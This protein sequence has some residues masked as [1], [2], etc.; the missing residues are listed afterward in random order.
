M[1]RATGLLIC[2]LMLRATCM[3]AQVSASATVTITA[4]LAGSISL[5]L[6]STPVAVTVDHGVQSGFLVPLS[7]E[8]NL[9]PRETPAFGVTAYFRDPHAALSDKVGGNTVSAG[10]VLAKWGTP[11]FSPFSDVDGR[12]QIFD[13]AVLPGRRRGQRSE[14]LELKIAEDTLASLPDG[15][16]Q[17][18]L[19]LEV[20]NY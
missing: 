10:Q 6:Q 9:D 14:N 11:S 15:D 8:W 2:V 13:T 19:Y 7:V 17:G 18:V 16:Y 5:S 3:W 12:V 4:R 20:R 1:R